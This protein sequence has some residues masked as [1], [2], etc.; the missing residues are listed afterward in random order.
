MNGCALGGVDGAPLV[1]RVSDD[2]DD[3]A[4]GL[5]ADGDSDRGA[6]VENLL[7][8]QDNIIED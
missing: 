4:Q 2:V 3:A 7:G 5:L 1:D 6:S 8:F